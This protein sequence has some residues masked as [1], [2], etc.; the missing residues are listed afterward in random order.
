[1]KQPLEVFDPPMLKELEMKFKWTM[2][3]HYEVIGQVDWTDSMGI[4]CWFNDLISFSMAWNTV[5]HK[6]IKKFFYDKTI[7]KVPM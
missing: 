3:E 7:A 6:D 2:W 5:P 4:V 1:M